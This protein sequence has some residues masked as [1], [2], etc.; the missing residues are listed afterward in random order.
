MEIGIVG[1]VYMVH[2]QCSCVEL[3]SHTKHDCRRQLKAIPFYIY[4]MNGFQCS[5]LRLLFLVLSKVRVGRFCASS[6]HGETT[7]NEHTG[8]F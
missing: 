7:D 6:C 3:I 2:L 5:G 1:N 4:N 8:R